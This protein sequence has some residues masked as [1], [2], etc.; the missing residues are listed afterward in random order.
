MNRTLV[1]VLLALLTLACTEDR[2]DEHAGHEPVTAKPASAAPR[3]PAGALT[4][5]GKDVSFESADGR[6]SGYLSAAE[7][8]GEAQRRPGLIV[9]HEWWGL[10]E[11]TR[12]NTD[13]FAAQGYVALAPDLYRGKNT[14]DPDEAHELMRGL[15]E[16]RAIADLKAAWAHLASRDDVDP[17]RIGVIGWCMGGGYAL[18]L[19]AEEPRLAAAVIAYGRLIGDRT[20][21]SGVQA[22]VLGIFAASDRGIPVEDVRT[23]ESRMKELD[24]EVTIRIY[25]G[26]GH[27][28]MNPGNEKGYAPDASR[29]AWQRIDT[30]LARHLRPGG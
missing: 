17:E 8:T 13:R 6:G 11:W 26:T 15:P 25:E 9:I 21:L 10:D 7:S 27:A 16:D 22:P 29:D 14:T 4:A 1:S 2:S 20:R 23:F 3:T 24:K 19:A 5:S 30:F 28:F 12:E 18:S